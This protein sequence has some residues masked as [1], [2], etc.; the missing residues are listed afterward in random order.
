[1]LLEVIVMSDKTQCALPVEQSVTYTADLETKKIEADFANKRHENW[2]VA[3][4][5]VITIGAACGVGIHFEGKDSAVQ[6]MAGLIMGL[7][8]YFAGMGRS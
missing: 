6:A 3:I 4:L 7:I 2:I 5:I 1:V 8:G